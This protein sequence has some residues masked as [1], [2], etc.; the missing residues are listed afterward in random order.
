MKWQLVWEEKNSWENLASL[1]L[2]P[3]KKSQLEYYVLEPNLH[4]EQSANSRLKC[5]GVN[6]LFNLRN[7]L[8]V[9][10]KGEFL[11]KLG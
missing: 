4:G 7:S 10:K 3:L 2:H 6:S 9:H 11:V 1:L 5:F 8:R